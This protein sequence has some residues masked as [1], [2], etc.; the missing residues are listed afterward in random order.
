VSFTCPDGHE[1]A[2]DDYC[3]QCGLRLGAAR[4]QAPSERSLEASGGRREPAVITCPVCREQLASGQ[5]YCENCGT[6][7]QNPSAGPE[8]GTTQT[9]AEPHQPSLEWQ[10]VVRCDR[11]YFDNVLADD[12]EFPAEPLEHTF[13][14]TKNRVSIGRVS[15]A[16]PGE[17]AVD[18]STPPADSGISRQHAR[19]ERQPDGSWTV[20]DCHS[21]NG[22]YLNDRAD[23]ISSERPEP[24]GD[25]DQIHVGAWTTITLHFVPAS[26]VRPPPAVSFGAGSRPR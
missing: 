18:L 23:P 15:A 21:T 25:G 7:I 20:I 10:L 13:A 16:Q 14:L 19:L 22:T 1:S 2:S 8:A 5:R 3:D 12:I 9:G 11:D 4:P 26:T 24:I 6:D 17:Q